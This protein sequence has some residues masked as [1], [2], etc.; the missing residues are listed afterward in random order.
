VFTIAPARQARDFASAATLF[1][2]Y[3][4]S[5]GRDLSYQSPDAELQAMPGKYAPPS[6]ELLLARLQ[7]GTP[8]GCVALRAIDP[9]G[10]CEMKRLYVSPQARGMGI[11][12]AL[13]DA[14][15]GVARGL[16]YTE[17]RLDSVAS[18]TSALALYRAAGFQPIPA[19][20]E[21]PFDDAVFLGLELA[22]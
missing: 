9:P 20:C 10:C 12:G 16:H 15:V 3:T 2:D 6:G 13:I 8:V 5:L 11:G 19:Y 17:M 4:R 7:D 18:L 21:N 14:I 22:V 1:Q